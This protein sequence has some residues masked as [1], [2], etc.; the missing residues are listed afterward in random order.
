MKARKKDFDASDV[1]SA[2]QKKRIINGI[3]VFLSKNQRYVDYNIRFDVI[4]IS[5][6][7]IPKHITNSW[8]GDY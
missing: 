5:P 3:Q 8:E 6:F 2:R 4:A 1:I 7:K